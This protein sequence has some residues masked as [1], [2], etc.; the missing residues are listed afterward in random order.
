M[1]VKEQVNFAKRNDVD[2][3]IGT[4]FDFG[5]GKDVGAEVGPNEEWAYGTF[6]V[7]RLSEKSVTVIFIDLECDDEKMKKA[8]DE[9]PKQKSKR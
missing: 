2:F 3:G 7:H 8:P 1:V 5:D 4:S 6:V 9:V